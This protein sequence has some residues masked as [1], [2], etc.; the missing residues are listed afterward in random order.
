MEVES[1]V[2]LIKFDGVANGKRFED[3]TSSVGPFLS[4]VSELNAVE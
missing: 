1:W 3:P 4:K 2:E